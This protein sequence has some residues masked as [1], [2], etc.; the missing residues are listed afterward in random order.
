MSINEF[1]DELKKINIV[2]DDKK[3]EQLEEY[4]NLV[5]EK[6]KVMNLTGITNKNEFY[7][8][9]FYDSLTISKIIDLN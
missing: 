7:L 6:N 8:K 5:I 1:I 9:H 2:I 4:Y 3:L